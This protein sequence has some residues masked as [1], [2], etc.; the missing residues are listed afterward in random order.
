MAKDT[1]REQRHKKKKSRRVIKIIIWVLVALAVIFFIFS[2]VVRSKAEQIPYVETAV[3]E[4]TDIISSLSVEGVVESDVSEKVFPELT[5]PVKE[6]LVKVG[7]RVKAGDVL[8]ILDTESLENTIEQQQAGVNASNSNSNNSIHMAQKSYDVA[9]ENIENDTNAQLVQAK[10]AVESAELMVEQ[11]GIQFRMA[12]D[13]V[14]DARDTEDDY[15]LILSD[16]EMNPLIHQR[17]LAYKQYEIAKKNLEQAKE[18]V[19]LAEVAAEQQLD[20][21]KDSVTSAQIGAQSTASQSV[22]IKHQQADLDKATVVAPV[23]GVVTGVYVVEGAP[24]SGM[25]YLIEDTENLKVSSS[26]KEYDLPRI[27]EGIAAEI[28][29]D[30]AGEEIY[31]GNISKIFPTSVKNEYGLP[32]NP[33]DP[34]FPIEITVDGKDTLLKIGSK[35]RIELINDKRENVLAVAPDALGINAEGQDVVYVLRESIE[36]IYTVHAVPVEVGLDGDFSVEISSTELQPGD[37]IVKTAQTVS[38][39]MV[40]K[41]LAPGERLPSTDVAVPGVAFSTGRVA[42]PLS[43]PVTAGWDA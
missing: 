26:I 36:D 14:K 18:A 24:P 11:S 28:K 43:P 9:K 30:V 21:L 4:K 7:D 39:G 19:K 33:S 17:E 27:K 10:Q 16:S 22:A 35:A 12:A 23:D 1:T 2:R 8:C 31:A 13:A 34:E 20:S 32:L 25:M 6:N 3:V 29:S 42:T 41:R 37:E 15:G 40:V 5:L 38:E